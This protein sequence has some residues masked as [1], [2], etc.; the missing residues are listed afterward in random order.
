VVH[1]RWRY[2]KRLTLERSRRKVIQLP[3]AGELTS[4]RRDDGYTHAV[5]EQAEWDD[6]LQGD[7]YL[8]YVSH[9][10]DLQRGEEH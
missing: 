7:I 6:T 8:A 9:Q 10:P 1:L 4:S 5:Y 2:H 3:V